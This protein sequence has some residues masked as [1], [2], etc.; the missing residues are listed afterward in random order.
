LV[1]DASFHLIVGRYPMDRRTRLLL[2]LAGA[3]F[4]V[5]HSS[6]QANNEARNRGVKTDGLI[7][8]SQLPEEV[9]RYGI[10]LHHH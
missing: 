4:E 3:R 6:G 5:T 8:L 7:F 9:A 10:R 1:N 2:T